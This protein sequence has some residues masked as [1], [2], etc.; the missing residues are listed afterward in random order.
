MKIS[1]RFVIAD[2][3]LSNCVD[4]GYSGLLRTPPASASNAMHSAH[5][6]YFCASFV[7][8]FATQ[9]FKD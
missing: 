2:V 1:I 7:F 6:G 5:T 4:G 8:Q 3:K 9:K